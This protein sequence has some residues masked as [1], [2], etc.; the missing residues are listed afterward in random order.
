MPT[1]M[2]ID[3][4]GALAGMSFQ[5]VIAFHNYNEP[6]ADPRLFLLLDHV[7]H[8]WPDSSARPHVFILS[9]GYFLDQTL[10][11]DLYAYGV[12]ELRVS[13]YNRKEGQR[14]CKLDGGDK[15]KLQWPKLDS[16]LENYGKKPINSTAPCYCPLGEILIHSTGDV[17][18]CCRDWKGSVTYGNLRD[19]SFKQILETGSMQADYD[20]L[21]RG[22]RTQ[23]QIC[24]RCAWSGRYGPDWEKKGAHS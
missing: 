3:I 14:L 4:L 1:W 21:S 17:A 23:H 8:F 9:N 10:L 13:V 15:L 5:K 7:R 22:D 11:N 18:L 12:S 16:R 24:K 2:A 6:M 19:R 20:R